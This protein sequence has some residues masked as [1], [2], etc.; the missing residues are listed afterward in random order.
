[1]RLGGGGAFLLLRPWLAGA[2]RLLRRMLGQQRTSGATLLAG[3]AAHEDVGERGA[4]R[5]RAGLQ[6]WCIEGARCCMVTA[7][8]SRARMVAAAQRGNGG[9]R[10]GL[11]AKAWLVAGRPRWWW[12]S[13]GR[14]ISSW[15][16]GSGWSAP[17]LRSMGWLSAVGGA[18]TSLPGAGGIRP[19]WMPGAKAPAV[20]DAWSREAP[21]VVVCVGCRARYGFCRLGVEDGGG[22]VQRWRARCIGGVRSSGGTC[23][24]LVGCVGMV[25]PGES[26]A[27][28][29]RP[30]ATARVGVVILLGGV[31]RDLC[32]PTPGSRPL[33]E[34][35]DPAVGSGGGVVFSVVSP[36]E[37]TVLKILIPM[38]LFT[39]WMC[40]VA[41]V[42][43]MMG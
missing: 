16:S 38:V 22:P 4:R 19:W 33:G 14:V 37:G 20:V 10:G 8:G 27:G 40:M 24:P 2:G 41:S 18:Q 43:M 36:L 5:R 25:A 12:R 39:D 42:A 35:Q 31:V 28:A 13:F 29:R 34:N 6:I 21:A 32:S 26:L 23:W 3:E 17:D 9:R 15:G 1:M 30:A 11:N 7:F